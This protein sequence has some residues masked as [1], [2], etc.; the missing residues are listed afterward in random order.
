MTEEFKSNMTVKEFREYCE[1]KDA[2]IVNTFDRESFELK[3]KKCHSMNVKIVNTLNYD[4]GGGCPTCGSW[5]ESEGAVIIKCCDCG[6]AITII[7]AEDNKD[8]W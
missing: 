4:V 6:N 7:N 5:L 8:Q 2:N 1:K 3:C